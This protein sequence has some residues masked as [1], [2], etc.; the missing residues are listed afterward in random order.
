MYSASLCQV[1]VIVVAAEAPCVSSCPA[2]NNVG[3]FVQALARDGEEA[4]A[5][6]LAR[7]TPLA[8]VCGRVC[9]GYC[10]EAC[11]RADLDGA[12]NVR[13]LERWVAD[14]PGKG[15][16]TPIIRDQVIYLT[17][18]VDGKDAMLVLPNTM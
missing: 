7:T 16:S 8:A 5:E 2:G 4:A 3:G 18:P 13:A 10:M 14:L 17:A 12:V 11:N 1:R 9:P 6:I 15:C